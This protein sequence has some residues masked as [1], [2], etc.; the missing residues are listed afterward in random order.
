MCPCPSQDTDT[1]PSSLVLG[2]R[3]GWGGVINVTLRPLY[4]PER[5][6]VTH[7]G[8]GCVGPRTGLDVFEEEQI[9]SDLGLNSVLPA[10][11]LVCV[12]NKLPRPSVAL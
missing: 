8:G 3:G 2:A 12:P 4:P 9:S 11:R 5:N 1:D 6:P 7:S 10:R